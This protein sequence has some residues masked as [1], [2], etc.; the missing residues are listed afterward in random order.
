[1][2]E[3]TLAIPLSAEDYF[4]ISFITLNQLER[5]EGNK[6]VPERNLW[7]AVLLDACDLYLGR[8]PGL[9][10]AQ[11]DAQTWIETEESGVLGFD[12]LCQRIAIDGGWLRGQLRAVRMMSGIRP[13][14][15]PAPLKS[16]L[17]CSSITRTTGSTSQPAS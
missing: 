1:M 6:A 4:G 15:K 5:H 16:G 13:V 14:L 10:I 9:P 3:R 2:E 11:W 8:K 17:K 12:W 7:M